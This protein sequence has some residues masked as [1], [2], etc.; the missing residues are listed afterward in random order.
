MKQDKPSTNQV[1]YHIV[2]HCCTNRSS[3]L[4][5]TSLY[6]TTPRHRTMPHC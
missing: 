5:L 1:Y 6:F 4:P 3:L 2:L